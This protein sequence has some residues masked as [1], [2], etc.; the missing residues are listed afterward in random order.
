M[1]PPPRP[2]SGLITTHRAA[3]PPRPTYDR[4]LRKDLDPPRSPGRSLRNS[5]PDSRAAWLRQCFAFKGRAL[6]CQAACRSGGFAPASG[7]EGAVGGAAPG[8]WLRRQACLQRRG[9]GSGRRRPSGA[10]RS[11]GGGPRWR[12]RPGRGNRLPSSPPPVPATARL[13][14]PAGAQPYLPI[15][16]APPPPGFA[17]AVPPPDTLTPRSKPS[18]P[19]RPGSPQ[20]LLEYSGPYPHYIPCG[21]LP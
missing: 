2:V 3:S 11:P 4:F 9:S 10:R 21:A 17:P 13:R 20:S 5:F 15:L 19:S 18:R 16:G 14:C 8:H 1:P 6:I 12:P 7:C